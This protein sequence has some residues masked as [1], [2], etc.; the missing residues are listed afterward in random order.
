MRSV[1]S[2]EPFGQKKTPIECSFMNVL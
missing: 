2:N 1:K